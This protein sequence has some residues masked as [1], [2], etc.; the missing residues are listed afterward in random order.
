MQPWMGNE[1]ARDRIAAFRAEAIHD[2]RARRPRADR[3]RGPHGSMRAALGLRLVS[4]GH[5]LLG[6]AGDV[7]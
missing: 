6:E 1:L 5:R 7:S 2:G 4:A 3:R